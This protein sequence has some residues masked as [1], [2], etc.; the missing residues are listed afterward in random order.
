M[1][2]K[3]HGPRRHRGRSGFTLVEVLIAVLI[4]AIGILAIGSVIP[5]G[6]VMQRASS[7]AAQSATLIAD[8]EADL[9]SRAAFNRLSEAA[10]VTP[11]Q[12]MGWGVWL[13]DNQWSKGSAKDSFLWEEL[14]SAE[15]DLTKGE[16][17]LNADTGTDD[18]AVLTVA[19]RLW[20]NEPSNRALS[21]QFVWDFV[22]RRVA[23]RAGQ[24]EQL[25]LALFVRRIDNGIV[26]RGTKTLWSMLVPASPTANPERLPVGMNKDGVPTRDGTGDYSVIRLL[27]VQSDPSLPRD[28]LRLSGGQPEWRRFAGEAGQRLVDNL[29]NAYTVVSI[30]ESNASTITVKLDRE[31]PSW[32]RYPGGKVD[33]E[34]SLRQ[35]AFTPQVPAAVGVITLTPRNPN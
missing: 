26:P 24:P 32:V 12:K 3:I 28:Q 30:V 35:V 2:A 8:I 10:N 31:L 4:I 21:P 23:R 16:F 27:D 20:P 11:I 15:L 9:L 29:G 18:D 33:Q 14:T 25:Q 22:G 17:R 1:T 19:D 34:F 7:D 13:N 5:V 6:V